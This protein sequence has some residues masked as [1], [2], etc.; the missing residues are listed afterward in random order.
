[1]LVIASAHSG[2]DRLTRPSARTTARARGIGRTLPV[3]SAGRWSRN[4]P[5]N[6]SAWPRATSTRAMNRNGTD[7][8]SPVTPE[9]KRVSSDWATPMTRPPARVIGKDENLP[10]RA[11][12]S[13][14]SSSVVSP[15]TD[16][17]ITGTIRMA[18]SPAS[19]EPS[20]QLFSGDQVRGPAE[21]GGGTL[22]LGDR[23]GAQAEQGVPVQEMEHG[24]HGDRDAEQPDAVLGDRRPGDRQ[25]PGGQLARHQLQAVAVA[26][27]G[28]RGEHDEHREGADQ[29]GQGGRPAQRADHQQ[30]GEHAQY[31]GGEHAA[32]GGGPVRHA[33][34]DGEFPL[35]VGA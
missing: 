31:G 20:A 34:V 8:A 16:R 21:R 9:P 32:R 1:M 28:D 27:D 24:R 10:T 11:A 7:E 18:V 22:V 6:G 12:A 5:R 17:P 19:A 3:P 25:Q 4:V 2:V 33:V 23:D 35:D 13:A 14:L 15:V 26:F 30:V 29:P